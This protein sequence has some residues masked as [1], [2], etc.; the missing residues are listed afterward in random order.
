MFKATSLFEFSV[1]NSLLCLDPVGKIFAN[2]LK[3]EPKY[4]FV[5]NTDSTVEIIQAN[6]HSKPS[7]LA[8]G[9]RLNWV[10]PFKTE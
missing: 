8:P 4:V 3:A 1:K 5:N 9:K 7:I 6:L 10:W 2:I